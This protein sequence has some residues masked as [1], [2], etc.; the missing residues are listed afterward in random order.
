MWN[1]DP[2]DAHRAYK[3]EYDR[4]GNSTFG[5]LLIIFLFFYFSTDS[6]VWLLIGATVL[7]LV[8]VTTRLLRSGSH[9][10]RLSGLQQTPQ[11]HTEA[12]PLPYQPGYHPRPNKQEGEQHYPYPPQSQPTG[13]QYEQPQAHYPEQMPP[14]Q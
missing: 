1:G 14:M 3:Y 13:S 6:W 4:R 7:V 8:G 12:Q 9:S 11:P 10:P 2:R 5:V